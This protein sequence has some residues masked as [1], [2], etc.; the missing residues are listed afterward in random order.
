M[1]GSKI[2]VI[3]DD[4]CA[5][6]I[7]KSHYRTASV[8][9]KYGIEYCCG[10]KWPLKLVCETQSIDCE[11]LMNEL[12]EVS[13]LVFVPASLPYNE[14]KTEFLTDYII[15][16]HHRY[17]RDSL[18][19]IRDQISRFVDEHKKKYPQ[20]AELD[21]EFT[22]LEKSVSDSITNEEDVIFPYIRQISHAYESKESY[23][24]LLIR[25][26]KRP[27]GNIF[28]P[29]RNVISTQLQR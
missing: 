25:T 2:S 26:L 15:N 19:Q 24:D 10:G 17:L 7:V 1:T 21:K 9:K 29:G 12:Q 8:F 18:P 4:L 13:R 3:T 5:A 22:K 23:T 27:T 28:Q 20:L 16:V 14:W 6:D 11:K